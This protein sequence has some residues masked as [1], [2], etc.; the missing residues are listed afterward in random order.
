MEVAELAEFFRAQRYR[1]IETSSCFWYSTR[2]F[3]FRSFPAHRLVEPGSL[4]LAKVMLR[5]PALA[6]RYPSPAHQAGVN[7]GLYVCS[8][9]VYDLA[10]L[11]P[12]ARSHTRRGLARCHV[13]RIDFRYLAHHGYGLTVDT[14]LRQYRKRPNATESQWHRYCETA[15][16]LHDFEAWGA[17]ID[18]KLAAFTVTVLVED[19]LDL[20]LGR[21][22][23]GLL[24][25]YPN[26]ALIFSIVKSKLRCRE[27]GYVSFGP[28]ALAASAGLDYFKISMGFE[29]K[30]LTEHIEFNPLLKPFLMSL[31]SPLISR[32]AQHYPENP[33]WPRASKVLRLVRGS[34]CTQSEVPST[35]VALAESPPP[36]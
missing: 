21:S 32:L 3:I 1:V 30:P 31:G 26:N 4:E 16:R 14:H 9:R 19:C 6:L 24:H 8:N 33:F 28:K 15:G 36:P 35:R 25:A 2:S 20:H 13:E 12:T 22:S 23:S 10:S 27:V 34:R 7:G 29:L 17:F 5:G 18:G 11:S